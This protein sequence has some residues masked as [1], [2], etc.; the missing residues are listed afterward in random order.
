MVCSAIGFASD[1]LILFLLVEFARLH[2]LASNA[3]SFLIG[4]TVVYVLSRAWAFPASSD[5]KKRF[6]YP[7]FLVLAA[8][9]LL[10][11]SLL[12]WAMVDGIGLW[13]LAGKTISAIAVFAFNFACRKFIVFRQKRAPAG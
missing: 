10:L 1:A 5:R 4:S 13:Y 7:V 2:Y 9:G 11:N 3:I 12:L 6:E 8:A